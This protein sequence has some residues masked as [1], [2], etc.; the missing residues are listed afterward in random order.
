MIIGREP[1]PSA[2]PALEQ[3]PL[4]GEFYRQRPGVPVLLAQVLAFRAGRGVVAAEL[5]ARSGNDAEAL[6]DLDHP[7][8]AEGIGR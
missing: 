4:A 3:Q 6:Q 5:E 8:A 7:P 1:P 2:V